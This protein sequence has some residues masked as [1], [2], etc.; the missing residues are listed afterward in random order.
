MTEQCGTLLY[1]PPEILMH[2][3]YTSKTDIW[4]FG[5]ISYAILNGGIHPF[6]AELET[7]KLADKIISR[8]F[9]FEGIENKYKEL[10]SACLQNECARA[11]IRTVMK[12]IQRI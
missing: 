7:K 12:L 4:N 9:T 8:K 11:D 5:L 3:K 1:L 6:A 10:L 2:H